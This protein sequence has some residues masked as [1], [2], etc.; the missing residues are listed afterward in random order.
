MTRTAF[1]FVAISAGLFIAAILALWGQPW[2]CTCGEIHLWVG[3][4]FHSGNSQHIADW[5]TLSHILH[6]VLIA[7][8]G[9]LFLPRLSFQWL[10]LIAVATGMAWEIIEHTEWVL[11]AFRATTI[12][13]GY[14][15]DSVLNAVAD[16]IWMLGG[17]FVA[18][19]M[20]TWQVI[21]MI[22]VLELTAAF[23]ARDS[24]TLSTIMLLF[25]VEALENWQQAI[26]PAVISR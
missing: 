10:F 4:I 11:G 14:Y 24:L 2:I 20:Q 19:A 15:S 23:V 21:V 26:N 9:R 18:R 7:L 13:Q 12:N 6:G 16:Y 5:Y 22:L 8:A 25:P 1:T 3:S 17:F